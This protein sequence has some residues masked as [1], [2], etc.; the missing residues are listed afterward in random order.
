MMSGMSNSQSR[1]A[2]EQAFWRAKSLVHDI[3][4][5]RLPQAVLA[6][7]SDVAFNMLDHISQ[8]S[9]SQC[10]MT[11]VHR[12]YHGLRPFRCHTDACALA[13]S[14]V[15]NSMPD[16]QDDDDIC[17]RMPV[18]MS[19]E[20]SVLCVVCAGLLSDSSPNDIP[21]AR[22]ISMCVIPDGRSI[23]SRQIARCYGAIEDIKPG[24]LP[25]KIRKGE[26]VY[27]RAPSDVCSSPGCAKEHQML[28]EKSSC[29]PGERAVPD[30]YV[31][32]WSDP[33]KSGKA[34]VQCLWCSQ[35]FKHMPV[36]NSSQ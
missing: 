8:R 20:G 27:E 22:E 26:R 18:Y 24:Y 15:K 29:L 33:Q 19:A 36:V 7:I 25:L 14:S 21:L 32:K 1:P 11:S 2:V 10:D 13:Y 9:M 12:V 35:L 34:H 5:N 28:V 23:E 30:S 6:R 17:T 16:H 31:Y 4:E 3:H